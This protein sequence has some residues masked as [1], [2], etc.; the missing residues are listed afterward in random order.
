MTPDAPAH[1][2]IISHA[3]LSG[4]ALLIPV[5]F[6]DD[7]VVDYF[8]RRLVRRLAEERAVILPDADIRALADDESAGCAPG[9]L[10]SVVL[11]PVKKILRNVFFFLELKRVGDL[12]STTYHRGLM[13][14]WALAEGRL[15]P[16]SAADVRAAMDAVL[17]ETP[18]GPVDAAVRG[19]L[20][21]SRSALKGAVAILQSAVPG[22]TREPEE[23][24]RAVESVRADEER[25]ISG[26]VD[27]LQQKLAAV[28]DEHFTSL[29]E[30]FLTRLR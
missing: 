30:R 6:V 2:R 20:G 8:R 25:Q 27:L 7:M 9:C 18:V 26:V 28:P 3:L 1:R 15:G 11:Y 23:V 17:A 16:K 24:K 19:A 13:L 5:P 21:Q 22:R 29:R 4:L 12:V 14:D 10:G